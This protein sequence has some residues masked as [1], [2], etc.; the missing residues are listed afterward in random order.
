MI[1][2]M[3]QLTALQDKAMTLTV[4]LAVARMIAPEAPEA[5]IQ[6]RVA[7]MQGSCRKQKPEKTRTSFSRQ[8]TGPGSRRAP[9]ALEIE[10]AMEVLAVVVAVAQMAAV[11]A[12]AGV[13]ALAAR[14]AQ[15]SRH[16]AAM[17]R[18]SKLRDAGMSGITGITG[19]IETIAVD[20]ATARSAAR[21]PISQIR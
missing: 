18:A 4:R 21:A 1:P 2:A 19:V 15:G 7:A 11:A 6:A 3:R 9:M 16:L 5:A 12:V 13:A 8:W 20:A 10:A 17:F 14:R